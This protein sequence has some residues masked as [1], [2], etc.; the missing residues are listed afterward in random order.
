VDSFFDTA[1]RASRVVLLLAGWSVFVL[2]FV[3][4]ARDDQ[5]AALAAYLVGGGTM[6]VALWAWS[7]LWFLWPLGFLVAAAGLAV[8]GRE[9]AAALLLVAFLGPQVHGVVVS[10]RHE[11]RAYAESEVELAEPPAPVPVEDAE[12]VA[13]LEIG[14]YRR[15][16]VLRWRLGE[17]VG[18]TTLL[19]GGDRD[20]TAGVVDGEL[21]LVSRFGERR[22]GTSTWERQW[23]A[24]PEELYQRIAYGEFQEVLAAHQRALGLLAA[25]GVRPDTHATDRAAAGA[26]LA[27]VEALIRRVSERPLR[28]YA[29][30]VVHRQPLE[31]VLGDDDRSRRRIDA[32]LR[33]R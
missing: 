12:T 2:A 25:R 5:A 29:R 8:D 18:V 14:G 6:I 17:G 1:F 26:V 11:L 27:D 32:W 21:E 30:S 22:L 19:V 7:E 10:D 23:P 13:A 9:L 31:H 4:L 20:R 3:S 16:G 28:F 24:T 15:L 33:E